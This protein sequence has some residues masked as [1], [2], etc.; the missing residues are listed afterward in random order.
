[1]AIDPAIE[2]YYNRHTEEDRLSTGSFQLEGVRTRMLIER[3]IVPSPAVVFDIGGAAGAYAT[4]LTERG[5]TVHLVDPVFR[6]VR[7][8]KRRG[9]VKAHL[10]SVL[11]ADARNL[12]VRSEVADVVLMLGP[13]YHLTKASD[14][15]RAL[16]EAFRTLRPGGQLFAAAITRWASA[17]H[18]LLYDRLAD[19]VFRQ[20]VERDLRDGQHRNPDGT[21]EYF[22]TAYFHRPEELEQEVAAAGYQVDGVY[23]IEG[24]GWLMADFDERWADARQRAD[25]LQMATVMEEE[26]ALRGVSA[27]LLVFATKPQ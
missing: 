2:S 23:G 7:E 8:A 18:G 10:A 27:H 5:Y 12:P 16:Q 19:P 25:L 6:L 21:P 14:R 17:F 11:R 22:T 1:M 15:T 24:P 20:I 9:T 13:L 26:P 4:W 3:M